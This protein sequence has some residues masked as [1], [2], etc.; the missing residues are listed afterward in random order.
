MW[1]IEDLKM[2][3]HH[4]EM[5]TENHL[6]NCLVR[7]SLKIVEFSQTSWWSMT[8]RLFDRLDYVHSV[9]RT[10]IFCR[11]KHPWRGWVKKK[12]SKYRLCIWI[13]IAF[14][15]DS[16]CSQ[17]FKIINVGKSTFLG[18]STFA[19]LIR[20]VCIHFKFKSFTLIANFVGIYVLLFVRLKIS[21]YSFVPLL[22]VC[23]SPFRRISVNTSFE[24]GR[25]GGLIYSTDHRCYVRFYQ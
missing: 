9:D 22:S 12:S 4:Q 14:A 25:V 3:Q 2:Q 5:A 1:C 23:C 8:S 18:S 7:M 6:L 13:N 10:W 20:H 15:S 21:L 24:F 17:Y 16:N 11:Q 19:H